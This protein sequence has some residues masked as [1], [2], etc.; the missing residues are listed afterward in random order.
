MWETMCSVDIAI[1][2]SWYICT[3]RLIELHENKKYKDRHDI[4]V[5]FIRKSML[6]FMFL[7]K[8]SDLVCTS[9]GFSTS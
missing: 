4:W 1:Y 6:F 7:T 2:I 8:S 5:S 9:V 3:N